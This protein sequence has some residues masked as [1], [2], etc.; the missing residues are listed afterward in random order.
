MSGG[1]E[2]VLER[3][4]RGRWYAAALWV[5][6]VGAVASFTVLAS[7]EYSCGSLLHNEFAKCYRWDV[8]I[9]VFSASVVVGVLL[10]L[11]ARR[12]SPPR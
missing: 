12:R 4:R 5:V 10:A 11:L 8:A 3:R 1:A 7:T 9:T 6:V 2:D